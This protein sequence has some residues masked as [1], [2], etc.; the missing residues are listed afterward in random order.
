MYMYSSAAEFV[1]PDRALD[2]SILFLRRTLNV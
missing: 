2:S 1:P